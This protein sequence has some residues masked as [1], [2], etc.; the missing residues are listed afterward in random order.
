MPLEVPTIDDRN[1][2][3]I[4]NEVLARIRI[5]N[6]EY[7]N[8]ND[9]DPGVTLLQLFSFM[10]ES[11]LYRSNLI[12]ERNRRKF[13]KLLGIPMQAAAAAQ[14]IATI[15]NEKGLLTTVTLSPDLELMAGKVPFRTLNSL[16]VL[17][18][19]AGIYY[20]RKITD[21]RKTDIEAIYAR[22][23]DSHED[24]EEFSFYETAQLE[25]P[26]DMTSV[27]E[28]NLGGNEVID[29]SLW[30][31]LL[32]RPGDNV[33]HVR[34]AIANKALNIGIM[35]AQ[36][37]T[38]R[39]L[40]PA[41]GKPAA[42]GNPVLVL[43]I[44]TDEFQDDNETPK[45]NRP[46]TRMEKDVLTEPGIIQ[47]VLPAADK[48]KMWEL[49][50]PLTAGTGDYPP[51]LEDT[52]LAERVVTWIRMW[53]PEEKTG[54][55]LS[56]KITWIGINA[57]PVTQRTHVSS[58]DLGRG[59]GEPDQFVTLINK[60]VIHRSIKLTVDEEL[61]EEVDDLFAAGPEI[62]VR[63]RGKT[64]GLKVTQEKKTKVFTVDRE[65]GEIR[66]GSG[67]HG[68]R[69]PKNAV[70]RASYDYGGGIQGNVNI[71]VINK[72]PALPSGFKV[73]NA[74]P[75]W[76]G[77]EPETVEE[78]EKNIPGYLRH[79]DRLITED[80]FKDI[81][82]RTPGVDI[83]RVEVITN[84]NPKPELKDTV[85]PGTVTIIAIPKYDPGQPDA[86]EPDRLFLDQICKYIEP[87]R[88]ITTEV[89][90]TGPEYKKINVSVG[91]EVVAGMDFPK[92]R[93]D[94]NRA[95]RK[96]LSPLEGG[97]EGKGWPLE[98]Y[99]VAKEL[100]AEAA[101]VPGVFYVR[102]L[103]LGGDETNEGKDNIYGQDRISM[104]GLE[105]PRLLK[106][107]TRLG[108]P[109]SLDELLGKV[110]PKDKKAVPRD[111]EERKKIKPIPVIPPEC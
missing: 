2:Q 77:D 25:P 82:L 4:L 67:V 22:L 56:A 3:Q 53:F 71:G 94:V 72:G 84:F 89:F 70:I 99:V 81:T 92:V 27:P 57:T 100:E 1:Y 65:S 74:L 8:F 90:I 55:G 36:D 96:Y 38:L 14:G 105:L 75:T 30:I 49:K 18:V 102:S 28:I 80:D 5:H 103:Y 42:E 26:L 20:K 23:Y 88:L 95:I 6:P 69:P 21:E 54:G 60:P 79:R 17:P 93:E 83:S 73:T 52:N 63:E 44:A 13:L 12:P 107:D 48:L 47:V 37:E 86:P 78:A 58:E 29:K 35:P 98:K 32:A 68:A 10:T 40:R 43:E 97:R 91:I 62:P 7:T 66:F 61:W 45:Y 34:T 24:A 19:E 110:I 87:R 85:S 109:E 51:A 46:E 9:S 31:A 15:N 50:E 101:R 59:T 39:T 106:V 104:F 108:D 64:L 16:D 111:K 76:G 41:S 11:L 33:E